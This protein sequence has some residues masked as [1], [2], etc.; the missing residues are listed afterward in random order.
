MSREVQKHGYLCNPRSSSPLL[1]DIITSDATLSFRHNAL[2][3]LESVW[4][5][6]M[7]MIFYLLD[8]DLPR[9]VGKHRE[10]FQRV[11]VTQESRDVFWSDL[12]T[13]IKLT[14]H[15]QE[16]APVQKAMIYWRETLTHQY[17]KAY[18]EGEHHRISEDRLKTLYVKVTAAFKILWDSVKEYPSELK[19]LPELD[20]TDEI[21][22]PIPSWSGDE[23]QVDAQ[24]NLPAANVH[25]NRGIKRRWDSNQSNEDNS[26]RDDAC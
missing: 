19:V 8:P 17:Q 12:G 5:V 26:F 18:E 25:R 10:N 14:C 7:F 3:D 24:D 1:G 2:H 15:I 13:F 21:S 16:P 6:S 23:P 9:D 4:W 20:R 22:G 11:F